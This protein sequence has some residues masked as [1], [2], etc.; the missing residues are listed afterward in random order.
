MRRFRISLI[1]GR[2]IFHR[3]LV[4]AC[5]AVLVGSALRANG[6]GADWTPP[7]R[8]S[9]SQWWAVHP[10]IAA[11]AMGQ[12]HV[13]WRERTEAKDPTTP[14]TET[15]IMYSRWDGRSWQPPIDVFV[16][17]L[18]DGKVRALAAKVDS[19]GRL[20]VLW[21][22]ERQWDEVLYHS[23]AWVQTPVTA[24]S[25]TTEQL[26]VGWGMDHGDLEVGEDGKVYV[27]VNEAT[28]HIYYIEGRYTGNNEYAWSNCTDIALL[29][30]TPIVAEPQIALSKNWIHVVW[31]EHN[32]KGFGIGV[33]YARSRDGV[34]W[35]TPRAVFQEESTTKSMTGWISIAADSSGY[36]HLVWS[37]GV[38]HSDGRYHE[39]S[40]DEGKTWSGPQVIREGYSGWTG[41]ACM[42]I[43]SLENLRLVTSA[44][45][46]RG[47]QLFY[48]WWSKQDKQW[49][50]FQLI[51]P[52]A[53][54]EYPSCALT[55]GNVLHLV[56]AHWVEPAVILYR[57]LVLDVPAAPSME[58]PTI[59]VIAPT[60][61]SAVPTARTIAP[62]SPTP[63]PLTGVS[64][65]LVPSNSW[66]HNFVPLIISAVAVVGLLGITVA[67]HRIRGGTHVS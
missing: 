8:I 34:Y 55:N 58:Y 45:A 65:P 11:D 50:D 52:D 19:Q 40:E 43:D 24:R 14:D 67:L 10:V 1:W 39:W 18:V 62:V 54:L 48:S 7:L 6:Q 41:H 5:L 33:Y 32:A 56:Y 64:S 27:V 25:W 13:F 20:H 51:G 61:S 37:R 21:T 26:M 42:E 35:E 16:A 9:D 22:G 47:S 38:G 66:R 46:G 30:D 36:I 59:P 3:L 60:A 12:L 31:G 53:G 28:Q 17:P 63:V 29:A 23:W 4:G 44:N 2:R 15:T 57:Q 49:R